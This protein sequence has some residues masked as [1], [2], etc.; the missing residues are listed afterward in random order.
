L[1]K[2]DVMIAVGASF[3]KLAV[4]HAVSAQTDLRTQLAAMAMFGSFAHL[5]DRLTRPGVADRD[6]FD[7][8]EELAVTWR[9]AVREPSPER[10]RLVYAAASLRLLYSLGYAPSFARAD[11][12]EA[13]RK[14]LHVLPS[15][16]LSFALSVTAPGLVF[17][18]AA[19][20]VEAALEQ[21]PLADRP[22]GPNTIAALLT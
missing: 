10:A 21:T 14:L 20:A 12:G 9:R 2:A 17:R 6:V 7:L 15:T 13:A 16:S 11:V 8:L 4:A 19:A 5:V 3:D 1:T 18:E 22:H